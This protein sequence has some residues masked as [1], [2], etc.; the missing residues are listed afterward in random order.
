MISQAIAAVKPRRVLIGAQ[1][2]FV[3]T[4]AH[5]H[6]RPAEFDGI[7]SVARRLQNGDI[8][9]DSRDR[10]HPNVRR[11]QRHDERDRIVGGCVSINQEGRRHGARIA[12]RWLGSPSHKRHEELSCDQEQE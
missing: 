12:K 4:S 5:R 11:T 9:G 2:W 3:G 10:H 7:E 1:K 6:V 8:A